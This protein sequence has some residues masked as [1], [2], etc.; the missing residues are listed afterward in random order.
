MLVQRRTH[1]SGARAAMLAFLMVGLAACSDHESGT[2]VG[3]SADAAPDGSADAAPDGNANDGPSAARYPNEPVGFVPW[4]EHDWQTWPNEPSERMYA[5]GVGMIMS[6]SSASDAATAFILIDDPTAPHG[7]GK[8]L[9]HRQRQ[10]QH[11]GTT[12]G[13]FNVFN[14]KPGTPSSQEVS[15]DAQIQL[16]SVYRS[17]WI[18]FEPDPVTGDWQ[19]GNAHMRTFWGNRF[20]GLSHQ[21]VSL[22][23]PDNPLDQ[24]LNHYAGANMWHSTPTTVYK[25]ARLELPIGVWRHHEY[26]WEPEGEFD[27][28]NGITSRIRAWI[29]GEVI[30]DR[31]IT[32]FIER[33][34]GNEHFA[35]VW[36]G[37]SDGVREQDD[38]IRFGDIYVSGS[39]YE[40]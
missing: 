28:A 36:L 9:R 29:D 34:F 35:M 38:F 18:Y 24:R 3:A 10:G 7:K 20:Y 32:H 12:S 1:G 6:T 37:G 30:I 23:S 4:F 31:V 8:S 40:E 19:F 16:K 2:D 11:N 17:H 5:S 25:S 13:I 21:A 39:L 15:Y 26:L 22:R 14:P 33:P 27:V